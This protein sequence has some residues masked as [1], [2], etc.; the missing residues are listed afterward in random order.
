MSL[1]ELTGDAALVTGASSG[2][3]RATALALAR[4]GADVVLA[5]R[6]EERLDAVAEAVRERY[7]RDAIVVPT[8]V[9]DVDAVEALV[10]RAVDAL[11]GLDV[12]VVNAGLVA[13]AG[14]DEL[15]TEEYRRMTAVNVDGTFFTT[16]AVLEPLRAS[17]GHLVFVGSY[18]GQYPRPFNPVYAATKWWTRGFAKSV[19]AEVGE[20]GVGVT[21]INPS[22]V[23]TEIEVAGESFKERFDPGEVT[24]PEEVAEAVVFA[25]RQSNSMVSELDL[26][27]RDK[28]TGF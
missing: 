13:G 22:E 19:S 1:R 28:F 2:I 23:R 4:E 27:R 25:A 14:V 7:A 16:R 11:G 3:G 20:A 9:S 24:E 5:A 26:F 8:D 17:N 6:R 18:A 10:D 15:S 21:V 12:A